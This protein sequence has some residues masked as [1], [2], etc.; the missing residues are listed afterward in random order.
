[1]VKLAVKAAVDT[2]VFALWQVVR[3]GIGAV[4]FWI[5]GGYLFGGDHS[6]NS[7]TLS[8]LEQLLPG[9][10]RTHGAVLCVLA[11]LVT[12]RPVHRFQTNAG[13]I[14]TLFYSL[15]TALLI[16]SDWTMDEVDFAA[17]AWYVL[18]SVFSFALIVLSPTAK[19]AAPASEGTRA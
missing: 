12:S 11:F 16:V 7:P 9:G 2:K 14:A 10:L 5:G 8:V 3:L 19:R 6:V 17:P 15:L 4:F 1:M 13:L 18:V